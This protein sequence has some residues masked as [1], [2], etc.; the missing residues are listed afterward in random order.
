[1]CWICTLV[2]LYVFPEGIHTTAQMVNKSNTLVAMLPISLWLVK[3]NLFSKIF[4][5]FFL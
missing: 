5:A 1:M 3:A 4:N 2:Q